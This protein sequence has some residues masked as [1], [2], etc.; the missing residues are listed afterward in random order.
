MVTAAML[1]PSWTSGL[2][3]LLQA[4]AKKVANETE[5]TRET[6]LGFPFSGDNVARLKAL[7][8]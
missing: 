2:F 5:N 4:N 8:S 6:W 7:K 1:R 3:F